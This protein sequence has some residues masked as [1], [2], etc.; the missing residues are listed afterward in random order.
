MND[1][2]KDLY[3]KG[4]DAKTLPGIL[5]EKENGAHE[6]VHDLENN[7]VTLKEEIS[8]LSEENRRLE[9]KITNLNQDIKLQQKITVSKLEV[10]NGILLYIKID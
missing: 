6:Y 3:H 8:E 9:S 7:L 2:E 4:D 1:K 10:T 5:Q